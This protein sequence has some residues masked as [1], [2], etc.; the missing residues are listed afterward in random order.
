M[1]NKGKEDE[2]RQTGLEEAAT[3]MAKK[4]KQRSNQTIPR[5]K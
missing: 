1:D 2:K 4:G 3:A 5:K